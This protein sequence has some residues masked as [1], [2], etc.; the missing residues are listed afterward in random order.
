MF[1]SKKKEKYTPPVKPENRILKIF[2][3]CRLIEVFE[4]VTTI[5]MSNEKEARISHYKSVL[6]IEKLTKNNLNEQ[7]YFN[8]S[9][10]PEPIP[11]DRFSYEDCEKRLA[12]ELFR[13]TFCNETK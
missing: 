9:T 7:Y 3:N 1:K 4:P 6:K 10:E 13:E 11:D 5:K 8:Y 12:Y 2:N